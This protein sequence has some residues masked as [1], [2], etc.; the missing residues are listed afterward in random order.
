MSSSLETS[1]IANKTVFQNYL[2]QH[3][4][5]CD[6]FRCNTEIK[7]DRIKVERNYLDK[8]F[9]ASDN[10]FLTAIDHIDYHPTSSGNEDDDPILDDP[11]QTKQ[12]VPNID[13]DT[14]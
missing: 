8:V 10:K 14:Q 3:W 12:H 4:C 7:V 9:N 13:I 1:P 2:K 5:Q 11:T 6:P